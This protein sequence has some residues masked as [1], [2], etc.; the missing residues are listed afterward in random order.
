MDNIAV[1]KPEKTGIVKL[2]KGKCRIALKAFLTYLA[3]EAVLILVFFILGVV[4]VNSESTPNEILEILLTE[5][6][7]KPLIFFTLITSIFT[8]VFAYD[9]YECGVKE[10]QP[11]KILEGMEDLKKS[12]FSTRRNV[13][14]I[15]NAVETVPTNE[16]EAYRSEFFLSATEVEKSCEKLC[17]AVYE[18]KRNIVNH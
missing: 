10:L 5:N 6:V 15:K 13:F 17:K 12:L 11:H 1:I 2:K 14:R 8:G 9:M 7:V 4:L 16:W 18:L 3:M